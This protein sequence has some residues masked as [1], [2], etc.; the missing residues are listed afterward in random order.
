[1][2]H[3][4][5]FLISNVWVTEDLFP[6]LYRLKDSEQKIIGLMYLL[7]FSTKESA[8]EFI[9]NFCGT[10]AEFMER[11]Y[12]GDVDYMQMAYQEMEVFYPD[13]FKFM[14]EGA[15]SRYYKSASALKTMKVEADGEDKEFERGHKL[16][17]DISKMTDELAM[18][19]KQSTMLPEIK[20]VQSTSMFARNKQKIEKKKVIEDGNS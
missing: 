5:L 20:K 2:E 16:S 6:S 9:C 18:I 17:T 10:N 12:L 7:R 4:S 13:P 8:I 14:Y 11:V 1:M 3:D 15:L 19:H